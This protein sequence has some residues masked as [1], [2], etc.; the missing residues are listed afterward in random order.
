MIRVCINLFA[1]YL[2][3]F[4][5]KIVNNDNVSNKVWTWKWSFT[6]NHFSIYINYYFK[7]LKCY[8]PH[9]HRVLYIV[10]IHF[11][12]YWNHV[13]F[14]FSVFALGNSNIYIIYSI[15]YIIWT[16]T[17]SEYNIFDIQVIPKPCHII[18][19][20]PCRLSFIEKFI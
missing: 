3:C 5:K 9:M 14:L 7:S 20:L 2:K 16:L 12:S 19:I 1:S 15:S 4:S 8:E 18:S 11:E 10:E 13:I 17:D 6:L